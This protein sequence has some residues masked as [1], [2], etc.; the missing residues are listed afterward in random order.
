MFSGDE[1]D[2]RG[3]WEKKASFLTHNHDIPIKKWKISWEI[4]DFFWYLQ[5]FLHSGPKNNICWKTFQI[6][7]CKISGRVFPES[8]KISP[9][10][11]KSYFVRRFWVN[12]GVIL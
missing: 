7:F 1:L 12:V 10:Y 2:I 8:I 5:K 9:S 6:L 3:L 11:K 4:L